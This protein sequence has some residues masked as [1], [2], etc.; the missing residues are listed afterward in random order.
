MAS[1]CDAHIQGRSIL[2]VSARISPSSLST[3]SSLI[4]GSSRSNTGRTELYQINAVWPR[5]AYWAVPR[6]RERDGQM[7]KTHIG[8][9]VFQLFNSNSA[10]AVPDSSSAACKWSP[11]SL[12]EGVRVVL[13]LNI[14]ESS[15]NLKHYKEYN[16]CWALVSRRMRFVCA[17][18]MQS[19]ISV[20]RPITT[21]S[22]ILRS[23]ALE[24]AQR[25]R[26]SRMI[27]CPRSNIW[28]SSVEVRSA[29][30]S[31]F[32]SLCLESGWDLVLRIENCDQ[33]SAESSSP[34]KKLLERLI[35]AGDPRQKSLDV[36]AWVH[37]EMV[38]GLARGMS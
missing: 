32:F 19:R 30:R 18:L 10:L 2:V 38:L 25:T 36:V 22:A 27:R 24:K 1:L 29:W 16:K 34:V 6:S 17:F 7:L 14:I 8:Q 37:Q 23:T 31:L 21:C 12:K 33:R 26:T 28:S 3:T 4:E 15:R 13:T 35:Q 9:W 20:S 5:P 11:P